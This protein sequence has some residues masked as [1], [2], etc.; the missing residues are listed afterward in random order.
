MNFQLITEILEE[1]E[2]QNPSLDFLIPDNSLYDTLLLQLHE[3]VDI[4]DNSIRARN[5]ERTTNKLSHFFNIAV[6]ENVDLAITPEYSCP[7][8]LVSNLL[9][10]NIFPKENKMWI[11]GCES[12]LPSDLNDLITA[13]E[14]FEWI[15]EDE[16]VRENLNS[17]DFLNPVIC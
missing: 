3:D 15:Y 5:R 10:D 11:I 4:T 16:L 9:R 12:I 6:S 13:N 1:R 8:D 2:L 14:D 7:W 17:S